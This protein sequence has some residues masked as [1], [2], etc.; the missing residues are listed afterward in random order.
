MSIELISSIMNG[1]EAISTQSVIQRIIRQLS[2]VKEE[3]VGFE[4]QF[5]DEDSENNRSTFSKITSDLEC[6]KSLVNILAYLSFV[7]RPKD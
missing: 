4:R 7:K 2:V 3:V 6:E 1:K 5:L